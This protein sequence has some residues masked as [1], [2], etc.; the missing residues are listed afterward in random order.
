MQTGLNKRLK[1]VGLEPA[2]AQLWGKIRIVP[3]L[4]K[5][6][7]EDLRLQSFNYQDVPASVSLGS[8]VGYYSYIPSGMVVNYHSGGEPEAV[9]QT[10]LAKAKQLAKKEPQ[11]RAPWASSITRMLKRLDK[12]AFRFL[13]LH[14]SLEAFMAWQFGGPQICHRHLSGQICRRGFEYREEWSVSGRGLEGLEQALRLFEWHPQQC[15]VLMMVGEVLASAFVVPHP[16]DYRALH[17][18]LLRDFFGQDLYYHG[19]WNTPQSWALDALEGRFVSVEGLEAKYLERYQQWCQE[20]HGLADDLLERQIYCQQ[21]R[22]LGPYTFYS[23]MTKLEE[24]L[25]NHLG[26]AMWRDNGELAYLKSYRL[27]HAQVRRARLLQGVAKTDWHLPSLAK[28]KNVS[29]TQ[30]E[31]EFISVGLEG[32]FRRK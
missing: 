19:L 13:P 26:E 31:S 23:F 4:R 24:S 22:S 14:L 6:V 8:G 7:R 27:S 29:L 12:G 32:I 28:D 21:R 15:G 20:L 1:L 25:E 10:R 11:G 16:Q 9:W 2:P 5:K 30:L 17:L 18:S 3:L